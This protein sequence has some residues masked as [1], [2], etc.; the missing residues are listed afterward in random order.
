MLVKQTQAAIVI[1]SALLVAACVPE[2]ISRPERWRG[3]A[4]GL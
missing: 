1:G 2:R 3:G 4:L